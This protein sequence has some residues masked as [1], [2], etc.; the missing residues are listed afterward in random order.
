MHPYCIPAEL[1][2]EQRY[3]GGLSVSKQITLQESLDSAKGP[4]MCILV[5]IPSLHLTAT[6]P[7]KCFGRKWAL[8]FRVSPSEYSATTP[9]PN[10]S[11]CIII[12]IINQHVLSFA[13]LMPSLRS[14]TLSHHHKISHKKTIFRCNLPS[15]LILIKTQ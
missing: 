5:S 10:Q 4:V 11:T 9:K 3:I 13:R 14:K 2:I 7:T 12:V 6:H 15:I 1:T 8:G